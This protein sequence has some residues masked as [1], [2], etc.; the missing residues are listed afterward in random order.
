MQNVKLLY[1]IPKK[2]T[3]YL[4]TCETTR[5]IYVQDCMPM[6]RRS[7]CHAHEMLTATLLV[8]FIHFMCYSPVGQRILKNVF[9]LFQ[10]RPW[11]HDCTFHCMIYIS[12]YNLTENWAASN[13][14]VY[15]F[16]LQPLLSHNAND[17]LIGKNQCTGWMFCDIF[18]SMTAAHSR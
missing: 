3:V 13:F 12:L 1:C 15:S 4:F 10:H 9:P 2:H 16:Q 18:F 8:L 6:Q 14:N 17:S 11:R 7:T 5:I